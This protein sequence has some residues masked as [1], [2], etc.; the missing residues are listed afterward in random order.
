MKG[1]QR[2]AENNLEIFRRAIKE[3]LPSEEIE[4][5]EGFV[6]LID[7]LCHMKLLYPSEVQRLMNKINAP[8]EISYPFTFKKLEQLISI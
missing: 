4:N 7:H 3:F 1:P 8:E 5:R 2:Q 6:Q